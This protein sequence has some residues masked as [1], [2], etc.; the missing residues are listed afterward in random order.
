MLRAALDKQNSIC[1]EPRHV[2]LIVVDCLRRDHVSVYG[3]TPDTTPFLCRLAEQ[4]AVFTHAVSAASW[5]QPAV[6]SLLSGRYPHAHGGVYRADPRDW[7]TGEMPEPVRADVLMLPEILAALGYETFLASTIAVVELAVQ[8]R[9][10]DVWSADLATADVVVERYLRWLDRRRGG[11]TFAYLHFSDVHE[12]LRVRGPDRAVFGPVADLPGLPYWGAFCTGET[13]GAEFARF[14]EQ[15]TRFYD[16][17]VRY[18]DGQL[19]RLFRALRVMGLD[20][21]VLCV[22]TADHGEELWDHADVERAHFYDP[23]PKYG[24]AHGHH[25]FG[26][27]IDVP[28]LVA[29]PGVA[30]GRYEQRVSGV[31]VMPTLLEQLDVPVRRRALTLDGQSLFAPPGARAI[32]SESTAYGYEKKA[33]LQGDLKLYVSRGD[34]IQWLYDLACDPDEAAPRAQAH[35]PETMLRRLPQD[36]QPA[37]APA[38]CDEVVAARLRALGY[39]E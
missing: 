10:A 6:A 22:L 39:M 3:Y 37:V 21:R 32:L 14:R 15:R 16:A 17:A 7:S 18:V 11:Q 19:E 24:I 23:R 30:A 13:G 4:A 35:V 1:A 38:R 20:E 9:F 25:L 31:D 26:E 28:L 8:E 29:G 27:V 12:P 34:G 33:V 2:L 36:A 5:T